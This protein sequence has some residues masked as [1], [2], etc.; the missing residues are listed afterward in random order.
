MSQAPATANRQY[1]EPRLNIMGVTL[2]A[3][4]CHV[5]LPSPLLAYGIGPGP[6]GTVPTGATCSR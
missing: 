1:Q 3:E 5:S 2:D 6:L 4:L